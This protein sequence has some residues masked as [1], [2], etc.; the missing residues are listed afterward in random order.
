[1]AIN[2]WRVMWVVAVFDCPVLTKPQRKAAAN[3]R[4]CLLRENFSQYQYSIYL[5]H[6]P[7]MAS[8]SAQVESLKYEVPK[9]GHVAFF[10]LTDKQYG[11]TREFLGRSSTKRAP[12]APD[13]LQLF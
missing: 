5:R 1:M 7:T 2:G 13:Q 6:F 8:A 10:M 3:F 12:K 9:G 11:M 4:K